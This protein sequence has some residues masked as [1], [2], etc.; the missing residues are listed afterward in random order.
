MKY[1]IHLVGAIIS[2]LPFCKAQDIYSSISCYDCD[3]SNDFSC[4]GKKYFKTRSSYNEVQGDGTY[5]LFGP[6]TNEIH[7][8]R[9][10]H[11]ECTKMNTLHPLSNYYYSPFQSFGTHLKTS[12]IYLTVPQCL[13]LDIVSK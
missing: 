9:M 13:V 7:T 5:N 4:S 8:F 3:S 6:S 2:L 12:S 1:Y 11:S 10:Y